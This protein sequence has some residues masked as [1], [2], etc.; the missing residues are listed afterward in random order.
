MAGGETL[1]QALFCEFCDV[2]KN[3][4]VYS[5]PLGVSFLKILWKNL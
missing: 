1:S 3:T 2:F 4:Y 5:T